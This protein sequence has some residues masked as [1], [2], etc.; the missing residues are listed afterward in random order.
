[1]KKKLVVLDGYALNP[2]DLSWGGLEALGELAVYDRT[3]EHLVVERAA[4]ANILY[5]NKTPVRRQMIEALPELEC[6]IVLA[7]GY[8]VVDIDYAA[9]R[10][11]PVM[12]VP[13]YGTAT[14]AQF[15]FALLLGLCNRVETHDQAV[16]AGEWTRSKDFC[17][18]LTPQVELGGKTFGIVGFGRIGKQV[19]KIAMAMGMK[20]ATTSKSELDNPE[21]Q[22][23]IRTDWDGLLSMSDIVSLHCPLTEQTEKMIN[24][25][26]LSK[27]KK[28]AYLINTARGGLIDDEDLAN[29][30]NE[31][32][33]AGAALDVLTI[34][35]PDD[36]QP[37]L[38]ANNCLITPHI[39]WRS[40]E[41]RER[42]MNVTV[43][44][45]K[46]YLE[47]NHKNVV[48]K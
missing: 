7:T 36:S 2:G 48:N 22:Q 10:G 45:T 39:A 18:F 8:N 43:E 5:T 12:N 9:E 31:G 4:E 25:D 35:P 29:A 17:F 40:K 3:P 20:V 1:M 37:L 42:I 44:N 14:V 24:R 21:W 6:I 16:K 23:V 33:I 38:K 41:A 32:I 15:T 11:I 26:T 28:S 46:A 34:E 30:L 27:M 47:G 13:T 19:A